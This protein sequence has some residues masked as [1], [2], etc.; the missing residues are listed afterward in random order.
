VECNYKNT[1]FKREGLSL[2]I[3]INYNQDYQKQEQDTMFEAALKIAVP[4]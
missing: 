3:V 2:D 4:K 1:N